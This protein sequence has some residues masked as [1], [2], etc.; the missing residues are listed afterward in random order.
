LVRLLVEDDLP[1]LH[2]LFSKRYPDRYD[3]A[4]T[5]RWFRSVVV[6]DAMHMY[7]ARTNDAFVVAMM[8]TMPWLPGHPEVN[9]VGICADDG[10]GWQVIKLLRGSIDWARKRNAA[11]WRLSSDTMYDVW[12]LAERVGAHH[13][14]PRYEIN[15]RED[16]P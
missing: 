6:K 1:W 4:T 10:A 12:A 13:V 11:V 14:R 2:N 7:A 3:A 8:V 16:T 9:V 15:L 5:E